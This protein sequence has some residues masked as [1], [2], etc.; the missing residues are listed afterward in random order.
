[1][2]S[3]CEVALRCGV[4][5]GQK[6]GPGALPFCLPVMN[7][8]WVRQRQKYMRSFH[9]STTEIGKLATD[10]K[11]RLL[12]LYHYSGSD[13]EGRIREVKQYYRGDVVSADDLDIY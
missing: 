1:M 13:H 7:R 3:R 11:P 2:G 8:D 10:A 5:C 4:C 12:V 6:H 9:T